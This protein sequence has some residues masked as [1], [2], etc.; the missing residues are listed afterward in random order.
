M[1]FLAEAS[2]VF[3]RAAVLRACIVS[4][5]L[6]TSFCCLA[7]GITPLL[8]GRAFQGVG[9][10]GIMVLSLVIFTDIVPLR[11]R[12]KWYGFVLGAWAL[13]NCLGPVLGGIIAQNSTWRWVFYAMFP[14]CVAGLVLSP[15]ISSLKAPPATLSEKFRRVDWIGGSLFILSGTVFLIAVSWGGVQYSW[16]SPG[17]IV[18][19]CLGVVGL[20]WTFI[21]EARWCRR[22]FLRRSLFWNVSSIVTYICGTIQGLIIYGQLY[23]IPLYFLAVK[24]Y[25]P[26]RTGLSTLPIMVTLVP[27]SMVTGALVTRT[28]NYRWPIWLGWVLTA[29]GSFLTVLFDRNTSTM[30]W[31]T[32]LIILGL[33]HGAVLNAQNFAAQAMCRQGEEGPAAAM[34]AFMR[35]SGM[36]LGVGVGGTVFQNVMSVKLRWEGLDTGIARESEAFVEELRKMPSESLKR[37]QV[38]DAYI[39]GLRGVYLLY[40]SI[41]GAAFLLSLL[42]R[43]FKMA[44]EVMSAHK[45]EHQASAQSHDPYH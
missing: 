19:L 11:F 5:T 14:F 8:V 1:P 31:A 12:P 35:Q 33:G 32:V 37:L 43:H 34:Y 3:G 39:Y 42:L 24:A 22:P 4:F 25:D 23:Y 38:L 7:T 6:G 28:A 9:G 30:I 20:T 15:S 36:P 44:G 16:L 40:S 29:V 27:S 45:L 26:V 18:P 2:H 10:A 41:S 17:T 13:G 21:Y